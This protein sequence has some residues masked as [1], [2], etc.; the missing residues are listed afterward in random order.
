MSKHPFIDTCDFTVIDETE[1]WIVVNKPAPLQVHP[2]RPDGGPTLWHGLRELLRYEI[3]NGA[4]LSI[5]NRLDR[6]TSGIV[7]VA[8]QKAAARMLHKAMMRR[9]VDKE[10][11]AIV[12]GWPEE[13]AFTVDQ[14]IIRR[15]DIEPSDIYNFHQ[16]H[17][18]GAASCTEFRVLRRFEK[19]TSNGSR[20]SLIAAHPLTGRMH[21][22]RVHL[23]HAGFPVVG[24]KLYGPSPDWYVRQI[25]HGWTIE[26]ANA[27]LMRRQALHSCRLSVTSDEG[28]RHEWIAPL[29]ADMEDFLGDNN[30]DL[31]ILNTV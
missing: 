20:F 25:H 1:D 29:P 3:E 26:A 14:P 9:E 6:D 13:D 11:R 7:L 24:D 18:A 28:I 16:V 8:K 31:R 22:I 2:S 17:P 19:E 27:L 30:L 12:W 21:Q 15:H 4:A 23:S 5:I 10:Y